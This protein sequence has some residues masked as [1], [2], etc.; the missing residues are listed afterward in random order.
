MDEATTQCQSR[1]MPG[2][3]TKRARKL[4]EA[5]SR[6]AEVMGVPVNDVAMR[7]VGS[8]GE[9]AM[10]G[11]E[12]A[13]IFAAGIF[14]PTPPRDPAQP[15]ALTTRDLYARLL[16][17]AEDAL[18]RINAGAM[19]R[20]AAQLAQTVTHLLRAA[21]ELEPEV[22]E[23]DDPAKLAAEARALEEELKRRG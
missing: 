8:K 22:G 15:R 4:A 19:P 6:A 18:D 14:A 2:S 1:T 20:D 16:S 12:T 21:R 17:G 3:P 23:H 5:R 9:E 10:F 7:I 13:E 11:M